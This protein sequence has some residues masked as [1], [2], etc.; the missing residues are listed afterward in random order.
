MNTTIFSIV[1]FV[2]A[3][4][5][6]IYFGKLFFSVNFKSEK[7]SLEEKLNGLL[8]QIEIQKQQFAQERINLDKQITQSNQDKEVICLSRFILSWANCCFWISI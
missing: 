7:V 1:L 3:L 5:I 4:F 2:I 8:S 6:G